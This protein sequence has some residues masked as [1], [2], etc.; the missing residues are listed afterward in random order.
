[1]DGLSHYKI[2]IDACM[3]AAGVCENC[4]QLCLK[5]AHPGMMVDCIRLTLECAKICCTTAQVMNMD[6][7]KI[8]EL[9]RICAEICDACA[10]E[11]GKYDSDHCLACAESC[12]RCA[13]VCEAVFV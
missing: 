8:K 13:D 9:A 5:D 4:A 3:E 2:C 10:E 1:M 12:T 11:C 6:G 7:T